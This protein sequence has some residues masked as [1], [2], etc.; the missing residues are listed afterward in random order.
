MKKQRQ[1]ITRAEFLCLMGLTGLGCLLPGKFGFP[2]GGTSEPSRAEDDFI[3]NLFQK[4]FVFDGCGVTS[5]KRGKERGPVVPGE[6]KR[7][8]GVDAGTRGVRP[9]RLKEQNLWLEQHK[10]AFY[11]IDR[12]SDLKTTKET[13]KYGMLYYTQLG[14][15]LKGS[16]E[17]LAEWKEGGLR[18]LQLTYGDNE[19]GGGSRSNEIPLSPLGK[20]VVKEMNRLRMVVDISH[21]GKRTTL[22]A[23]NESDQPVTANHA[24]VEKLSGHSRNKSDEELRAIIKTGGVVGVTLINRFILQNPSRPATVDDFVD[25]VDYLVEF[26]GIDHVGIAADCYLDGSQVYEVDFSD[27]YLNSYDRWKHVARR[28]HDKGYSREDIQKVLG[29]NFKRIFEQVLDP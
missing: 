6:I 21:S 18:S 11:R 17:P 12:A 28:L 22:D 15:D 23:C 4:S 7:L 16:V 8:T 5:D 24:N 25:H 14:F 29:L 2:E 9:H 10:D 3:E 20:Q 1:T 26:L 13:N 19:L 27:P